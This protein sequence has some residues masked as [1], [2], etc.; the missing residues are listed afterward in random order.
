MTLL[1]LETVAFCFTGMLTPDDIRAAW[2]VVNQQTPLLTR[3]LSLPRRVL[4]GSTPRGTAEAV[5]TEL[6]MYYTASPYKRLEVYWAVQSDICL[7]FGNTPVERALS[8]IGLL[9]RELQRRVQVL[10]GT[11]CASIY[12]H[13]QGDNQWIVPHQPTLE[14]GYY[15]LYG[16]NE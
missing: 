3:F 8:A 2:Q 9:N 4:Y 1:T 13:Q 11:S 12:Q 15:E 14:A 5:L 10:S 16:F 6:L 7:A